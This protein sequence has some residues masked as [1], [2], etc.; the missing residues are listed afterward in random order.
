M[1]R[2]MINYYLQM[3][4]ILMKSTDDDVNTTTRTP[5]IPGI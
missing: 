5:N 1:L 4:A 2:D 3:T